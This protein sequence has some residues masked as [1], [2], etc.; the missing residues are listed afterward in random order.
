MS[1]RK[2]VLLAFLLLGLYGKGGGGCGFWGNP[3]WG[4]EPLTH[5]SHSPPSW[6]LPGPFPAPCQMETDRRMFMETVNGL[7]APST[8]GP[9]DARQPA[10]RLQADPWLKIIQ[11][12]GCE[13][14]N[15]QDWG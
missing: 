2:R 8:Q 9:V 5:P 14:L 11:N 6:L 4:G 7:A 13:N 10:W 1:L 12:S 15:K 3:L